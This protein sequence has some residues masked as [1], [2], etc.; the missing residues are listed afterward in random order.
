MRTKRRIM[1]LLLAGLL[2][3]G[4]CSLP[5]RSSQSSWDESLTL[6]A[7]S[8]ARLGETNRWRQAM[9]GGPGLMQVMRSGPTQSRR[10]INEHRALASYYFSLAGR[11]EERSLETYRQQ[12]LEYQGGGLPVTIYE[13]LAT[14]HLEEAD[15][16]QR[17]RNRGRPFQRIGDFLGNVV[18]AVME[19]VGRN[20]QLLVEDQVVGTIKGQVRDVRS[21]IRDPI[22]F[23]RQELRDFSQG[24]IDTLWQRFGQEYNFIL[25]D[26]VRAAVDPVFIRIRDDITGRNRRRTQQAPSAPPADTLTAEEVATSQAMAAEFGEGGDADDAPDTFFTSLDLCRCAGSGSAVAWSESSSSVT[27]RPTSYTSSRT[28]ENVERLWCSYE[29]AY[30]SSHVTG[31]IRV[32]MELFRVRTLEDAVSLFNEDIGLLQPQVAACEEDDFCTVRE[33]EFGDRRG[34]YFKDEIYQ[35]GDG[36]VLPSSNS[37]AL[38]EVFITPEG[39]FSLQVLA[40]HPEMETGDSWALDQITTMEACARWITGR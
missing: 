5:G 6:M 22:R 23:T 29:E 11:I 33:A 40:V 21:F 19:G 14:Y 18:S 17:R 12:G 35:R 31:T 3:L 34:Y 36:T 28:Y 27:S 13:N 37:A 24:R 8:Y 1:V 38:T 32:H 7:A 4:G 10:Q 39:Y 26:V 20:A 2:L 15:R 25:A 9:T 30:Q 16:L